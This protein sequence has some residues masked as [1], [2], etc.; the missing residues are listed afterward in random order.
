MGSF[1]GLMASAVACLIAGLVLCVL[2]RRAAHKTRIRMRKM[3]SSEWYAAL[4]NRLAPAQ[5][6]YIEQM[7]VSSEGVRVRLLSPTGRGFA[8]LMADEGLPPLSVDRCE[9]LAALLEEAFPCLCDARKYHC[10]IRRHRLVNGT[11]A[12]TYAYI[13]RNAYKCAVY[14][15]MT[16][17]PAAR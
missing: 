14:R 15:N 3:R 1:T 13:I 16:Y 6:R 5:T 10:G 8:Y 11:P 4:L 2:N 12:A 9:A 17:R 7:T